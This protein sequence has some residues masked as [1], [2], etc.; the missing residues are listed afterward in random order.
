MPA[1]GGEA[2]QIT[3]DG[4]DR[5]LPE[6]S[7]D[8]KFLYY[9]KADRYPERCSVWR[10]PTG[11]GEE[12]K[13]YDSTACARYALGEHGIYFF[14][15]LDK[16]GR[17]DI[18]VYDLSTGKTRK[19]LTVQRPMSIAVSPDGH[20]IL[21]TQTT[22]RQRPDAGGELPIT[23]RQSESEQDR[24]GSFEVIRG[25]LQPGGRRR[26]R[27]I[28]GSLSGRAVRLVAGKNA[29]QAQPEDRVRSASIYVLL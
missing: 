12:T 9:L 23:V 2:I 1:T 14:T 7:S 13:W 26:P 27:A 24:V 10:M 19:I 21:Y 11:G 8:G 3:R 18:I 25:Y 22:R 15:P 6:E 29:T 28:F 5:D 20:T 17:S 16:Q 4:E